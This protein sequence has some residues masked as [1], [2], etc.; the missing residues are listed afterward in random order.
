MLW[1]DLLT[2]VAGRILRTRPQNI[3]RID[4][5]VVYMIVFAFGTTHLSSA[6]LPIIAVAARGGS[7]R[8]QLPERH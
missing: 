1:I 5:F 3:A 7:P 2:L 4:P 8:P 6:R